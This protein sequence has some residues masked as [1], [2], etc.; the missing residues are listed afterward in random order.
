MSGIGERLRDSGSAFRRI[1]ANPAMR[2]LQLAWA[3]S[4]IGAWMGGLALA[5]FAFR[6]DGA[7]AV[8]VLALVRT[9]C[10]GLV[11]PF[12][13]TLGD[14]HPRVRVM[15][16][17]DL[18]RVVGVSTMAA[19]VFA[20]GPPLAVYALA[21]VGSVAGTAFRPAQAALVPSL[22]R[23]PEELTASNVASSTTEGVGIF[24]GP[25]LGG[26]LLA[27]TSTEVVFLATAALFLASALLVARIDEPRAEAEEEDEE[28]EG[29]F[30]RET[31]DGFTVLVRDSRVAVLVGLF[32]AQTFVD[33]ALG[34][35]TVILA[36]DALDIGASGLGLLNSAIGVGGLLGA[37]AAAAL[38]GRA[39]LA[40]DFGFGML[41]WGLPLV[42][43]ALWL[44]PAFAA[45][46]F[47]L[48]GIGN[49][50]VD[51]TGDT[52]L[53]RG[54]PEELLARVFA[55]MESLMLLTIGLGSITAPLLAEAFGVRWALA[56]T[57]VLL[58]ALTLASWR[59]LGRID[60][61]ARVPEHELALLRTLP[62]FAPLDAPTLEYLAG[63]LSRRKVDA[64]E[65]VCRKGEPGDAFYVVG[66]G[67]VEVSTDGG[68][69]R[70]LGSGDFFGEIALLRDVPRTATV[71]AKIDSELYELAGEDF[72]AALTGN[73]EALRVADTVVLARLAPM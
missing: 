10:A 32:A 21:I 6:E 59:L 66:E 52:L 33:G 41:L 44:E 27:A 64:G 8:G 28:D 42:L 50:I 36:L 55:I 12:L 38:I 7:V 46:A 72:V 11:A 57:G 68:P 51:V 16:A 61:A 20:G 22:A 53:Q 39:R 47:V 3:C 30:L 2:R 26:F 40:T 56:L 49:T 71:V 48:V 31:L 24:I 23:T 35:L 54:V 37:V 25:A 62:M 70:S 73:A 18:V 29:S 19:I 69:P 60:A 17:S 9:V 5:V 45:V 34:V 13:G 58:P 1:F 4:N 63:R 15:V 14:R 43:I 65:T 67:E